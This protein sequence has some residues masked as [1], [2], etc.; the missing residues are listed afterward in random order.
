MNIA[1][2]TTAR[3]AESGITNRQGASVKVSGPNV[4][5][6]IRRA[7]DDTAHAM[8]DHTVA[9]LD[10]WNRARLISTEYGRS[11]ATVRFTYCA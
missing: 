8:A 10:A 9:A 7:S 1:A 6:S 11:R 5:I 2:D 4:T 3:L